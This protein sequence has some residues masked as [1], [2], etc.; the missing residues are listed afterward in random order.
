MKKV[1]NVHHTN[2]FL[3]VSG[4][5]IL[6]EKSLLDTNDIESTHN[7]FNVD[8]PLL[9]MIQVLMMSIYLKIAP[10]VTVIFS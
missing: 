3:F 9:N 8:P 6:S 2:S 10:E 4:N 5:K 1:P 7:K